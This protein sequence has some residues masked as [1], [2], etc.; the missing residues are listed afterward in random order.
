[1]VEVLVVVEKEH[2]PN[3]V[4]AKL[5][6]EGVLHFQAEITPTRY[7][8]TWFAGFKRAGDDA[9]FG[10]GIQVENLEI[11]YLSP[12][13]SQVKHCT[14]HFQDVRPPRRDGVLFDLRLRDFVN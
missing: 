5:V 6:K 4:L 10:G 11:Y 7:D 12:A 8:H 9:I 1:V 14:V 3:Y 2:A 13:S